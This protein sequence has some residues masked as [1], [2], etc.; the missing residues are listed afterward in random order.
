[1]RLAVSA[2]RADGSLSSDERAMILEHARHAGIER[3]VEKE[4]NAPQPL[5]QIVSGVSDPQRRLDLYALAFTIV[6]A[7][8]QVS[9][10]ERIYLA[11]LA[12][13]LGVDAESV[14]RIEEDVAAK[15]DRTPESAE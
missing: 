7:D 13:Q 11:Q 14:A 2:A 9:G 1:V 8:E 5:S 15:I 3:D 4:L 12:H 10:A 6:R